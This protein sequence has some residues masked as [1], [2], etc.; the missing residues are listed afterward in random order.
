MKT[1]SELIKEVKSH[2]DYAQAG[3]ILCHNGV[4]RQT[5]RDGRKVSG[6]SVKVDWSKL[7]EIVETRKKS[8]GI[9][10]ILVEINEGENLA[11]GDDV[12]FIVVAGDIRE[13]VIAALTDTLNEIK[14]G[15]TSKT[16]YFL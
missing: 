5:S 11:V 3:M 6:L 16:E 4:V 13:N 9:I 1:L 15:V 7:Q 2:P 12:M 10:E 8:Q 14:T